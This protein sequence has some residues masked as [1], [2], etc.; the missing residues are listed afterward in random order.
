MNVHK[1]AA[2]EARY[3]NAALARQVFRHILANVKPQ[4]QPYLDAIRLEEKCMN[5][6]A[7]LEIA[8]E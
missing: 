1:G 4:G 2:F 5:L 7:A 3:G 6:T 8:M